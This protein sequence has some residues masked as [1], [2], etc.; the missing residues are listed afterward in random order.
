MEFRDELTNLFLLIKLLSLDFVVCPPL[1]LSR[2]WVVGYR[3]WIHR[4]VRTP[5]GREACTYVGT[6]FA[7]WRGVKNVNFQLSSFWGY[8]HERIVT[9]SL[10]CVPRKNTISAAEWGVLYIPGVYLVF[11]VNDV[12]FLRIIRS[13]QNLSRLPTLFFPAV[14]AAHCISGKGW[15]RRINYSQIDRLDRNIYQGMPLLGAVGRIR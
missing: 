5:F 14:V 8:D 15:A 3:G 13:A 1:S 10:E 9:P 12:T 2:K 6:M 4:R 11:M 7:S